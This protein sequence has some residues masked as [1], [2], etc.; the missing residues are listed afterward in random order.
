MLESTRNSLNITQTKKVSSLKGIETIAHDFIRKNK[1]PTRSQIVQELQ[2]LGFS[3][4]QANQA[5]R[6]LED[7]GEIFIV[8][9]SSVFESHPAKDISS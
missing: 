6:E 4:I 3:E 8:E 1:S 5:L 7:N 9:D 2:E